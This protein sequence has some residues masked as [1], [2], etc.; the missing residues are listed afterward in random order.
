MPTSVLDQP[1]ADDLGSSTDESD[2]SK[3]SQSRLDDRR[4]FTR[5][6]AIGGALAFVPFILVLLNFG[7]DP[8][9]TATPSGE[10]SNF[11][12][13][14]ARALLDGHL[15]VP[16]GSLGIEAFIID[17]QHFMYFPPLSALLR[18]PL[19]LFTSRLDGDLSAV[20]ILIAWT[21][22]T[23]LVGM[24]LWR[25]R[26]ILLRD[27]PLGRLEAWGYG[28]FMLAA[29]GGS[30]LVY[31][32][33]LPW[34]YHE[35]Y[36]WG[37]ACAIGAM[38]SLAGLIERPRVGAVIA[39]GAWT[40]A[41]VL[42]RTTAG[43]ACAIAILMCAAWFAMSRRG[44]DARRM[45]WMV[46]VAG[47]VPLLIGGIINWVKFR[48]PWMFPLEDQAWTQIS[49]N[50]QQALAENGGGLVGPQFFTTSFVNYLRPDGIR[51][52]SIFPYITL[53]A[54]PA[55]SYNG[56]FLDESYRT[57]SVVA[58]MP[59]LFLLTLWG[60]GSTFRP[61]A[62]ERF[63]WLRIPI[64]GALGMTVGVMF[65]GWISHRYTAEFFPV[66]IVAGT[67]G[68]FE[69]GRRLDGPAPWVR[70]TALALIAGFALF[71]V[72]ANTATAIHTERVT[73]QGSS[74][75]NY[76]IMQERISGLT[77]NRLDAYVHQVSQLPPSAG[78]DELWI[79]NNCSALHIATGNQYGPWLPVEARDVSFEVTVPLDAE[80]SQASTIGQVEL[81]SFDGVDELPLVLERT[82]PT[83]FRLAYGDGD[84]RVTWPSFTAQP[85]ETFVISIRADTA[86]GRYNVTGPDSI[87]IPFAMS[88]LDDE[89]VARPTQLNI[90]AD[91]E[92]DGT[93]Q[94]LTV[95]RIDG[96]VPELCQRLL[97]GS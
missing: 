44:D 6:T 79:T 38:F 11:Y 72:A 46:A 48:H 62:S 49:D 70:R 55:P 63:R 1:F 88:Q 12:D 36:A 43:W 23:V 20:S 3:G 18:M 69:L 75:R 96:P 86:A 81:V 7:R 33:S 27:R 28:A 17:G 59:G 8:L 77:G 9:R 30:V 94:G 24:L 89:W 78:T 13:L 37:N 52:V 85:G 53:P 80:S 66:L 50:R 92:A 22:T 76:V 42:S 31:I 2:E 61:K 34:V 16:P 40:T 35:A 57:G 60:L 93:A 65:F 68:M 26:T 25:V 67:V 10:F 87:V 51:F 90:S 91:A 84:D 14:Q 83:T 95:M 82:G 74:L 58:F 29:C 71:G 21:I 5:A 73:A 32:A 45:W 41:A 54:R 4:R 64:L 19:F 15:D 39:T 97:D 47:L 56:A